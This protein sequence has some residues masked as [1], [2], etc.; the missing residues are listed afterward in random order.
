MKKLLGLQSQISTEE[1]SELFQLLK[2]YERKTGLA[3]QDVLKE[4]LNLIISGKLPNEDKQAVVDAKK[5]PAKAKFKDAQ[6][7]PLKELA[8][9]EDIPEKS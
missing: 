7:S 6:T 1:L 4:R 9:I 5:H 2:R 8:L 3:A